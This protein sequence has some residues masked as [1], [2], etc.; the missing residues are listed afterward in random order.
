M[1]SLVL[2]F[3]ISVM[4]FALSASAED[5]AQVNGGKA[6]EVSGKISKA[7]VFSGSDLM[8]VIISDDSVVHPCKID[9]YMHGAGQEYLS[10][11]L[12]VG[13]T[14][15]ASGRYDFP[16]KYAE[17][18]MVRNITIFSKVV[19]AGEVIKRVSLPRQ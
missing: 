4:C 7:A 10:C 18:I 13:T 19:Y 11:L 17:F 12:T 16:G 15:A 2:F 1:R 8:F 14:V 9:K 3:C 6:I 5:T